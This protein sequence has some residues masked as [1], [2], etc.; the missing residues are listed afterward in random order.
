MIYGFNANEIFQIAI[1]IEENGK[2]FYEKAMELIDDKDAKTLLA[3]LAKEEIEHLK[4]FTELKEQ[5]PKEAAAGTVW[6]PEND[7][8]NYLHM[9]ADMNVFSSD[10]NL[11]D[12]L[13]QVKSVEDALRF[14][15]QFEKDSIIFFLTIQDATDEAKGRELIGQLIEEEKGHLKKLSLELRKHLKK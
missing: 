8:N 2:R 10:F 7:M 13:S 5:L 11:K 3:S 12:E 15:I 6:D 4:K 1:N 14:G 9:V